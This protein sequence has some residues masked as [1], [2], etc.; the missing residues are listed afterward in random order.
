MNM[1]KKLNCILL[2]DDDEATNFFNKIIIDK[3]GVAEHVEITWNGREALEYLTNK[4]KYTGQND[5]YPNPDLILLDINMPKM[6]GWDFLDEYEKLDDEQKARIIIVMLT[7]SFNP[8]DKERA[9]KIPI[10][11]GFKNKPLSANMLNEILEIY[12]PDYF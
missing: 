1:K 3:S 4:G 10:I 5:K 6:D 7:T 8:D 9:E 11:N 12:F 2:V